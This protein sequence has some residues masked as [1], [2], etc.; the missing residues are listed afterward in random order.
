VDTLYLVRSSAHGEATLTRKG[1]TLIEIMIVVVIIGILAAITI[2][3]HGQAKEQAYIAMMKSDL[4]NLLSAE[5]SYFEEYSAYTT[6]LPPAYYV[7][8]DVTGPT[9]TVNGDDLTA[10]AGSGHTSRTCAIFIGETPISPA[11]HEAEPTCT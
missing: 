3:K 2:L 9:I 4:R 6:A 11:T 1:F 5:V 8:S 10:W 7:S